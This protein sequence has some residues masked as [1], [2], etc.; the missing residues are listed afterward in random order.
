M[1]SLNEIQYRIWFDD[2]L[3]R[4][5]TYNIG[6]SFSVTGRLSYTL[7]ERSL[8]KIMSE[9]EPFHSTIAMDGKEPRFCVRK[10]F[11]TPFKVIGLDESSTQEDFMERIDEIARFPFDLE[12]DLPCRFYILE[13]GAKSF[14]V[15]CFHH[16]V[17]DA[18]SI[19]VFCDRLSVIYN[20]LKADCEI[21]A[22]GLPSLEEFNDYLISSYPEKARHDDVAYWRNYLKD[23]RLHTSIPLSWASHKKGCD[24]F[25]WQIGNEAYLKACEFCSKYEVTLFRLFTAVW[26]VVLSRFLNNKDLVLDYTAH[27]RT[28]W[29]KNIMGVCFNNLP[30]RVEVDE[31]KSFLDLLS[32]IQKDRNESKP[33][34]RATYANYLKFLR[35]SQAH[36]QEPPFNVGINYPIH[37]HSLSFHF[38]GCSADFFH[39]TAMSL[40]GDLY[41]VIEDDDMLSCRIWYSERVSSVYAGLLA[42][43]FSEVL[44]KVTDAPEQAVR[45]ISML[46]EQR[47]HELIM[48]NSIS[49]RSPG[50]TVCSGRNDFSSVITQFD[51]IALEHCAHTAFVFLDEEYSYKSLYSQ[52]INIAAHIQAWLAGH[53]LSRHK[54]PIA[55]CIESRQYLYACILGIL[56]CGCAYIPIDP[57]FPESRRDFILSDSG[58]MLLLADRPLEIHA[59]G[60]S[61]MDITGFM[62]DA[63]E[64]DF[65]GSVP[66]SPHDT[67]YILYTSGTTGTPKGIPITHGNLM[68]FLNHVRDAFHIDGTSVVLQYANTGFDVSIMEIFM[69]L[70]RGGKLV[71]PANE[72]RK[73]PDAVLR[74]IKR[75]QVNVCSIAPAM[76]TLLPVEPLPCVRL[77]IVGG[78]S[79][80]QETVDKWKNGQTFVN[81]YGPTE[82]TIWVT[83]CIMEDGTPA[84]DIGLPF[85]GVSCYVLDEK[86]NLVPDGIAGELYI[87][88]L[89][90]TQGYL[91][92][93]D[94]NSE[95]FILNPYQSEEDKRHG[96]NGVLYRSG[97]L[98]KRM[99]DNH[100][101]FLG[102][103]D[104]QVKIRGFR[105]ELG[106][107][108][109]KLL[110]Y[111]GVCQAAVAASD[112]RGRKVL[113]AYIQPAAQKVLDMA[114]LKSFLQRE[115]PVYML[116]AVITP[117]QEFPYNSN[118][119][120]DRKRL[121]A[122][123]FREEVR[124]AEAP[125]TGTERRLASLWAALLPVQAIGRSDSLTSLGGDSMAVIQLSFRI[126]EEFGFRIKVADIYRHPVLSDL[127]GFIDRHS[128]TAAQETSG[129]D[130]PEAAAEGPVPLSPTQFSLWLQCVQSAEMKDAYVVPCM[131]ECPPGTDPAV[132]EDALNRLTEVQDAFRISFP[133]DGS[134]KPFI[135]VAGWR[136]FRLEVWDIAGE[137]LGERLNQDI[138]VS[139]DLEQGPLFRCA[140]YRVDGRRYVCSLVMHHLIS[141]G[142]SVRLIRELLLQAVSGQTPDWRRA[143]G[144]YVR[145]ALEAGRFVMTEAYSR[146]LEYW[147]K[148]LDGAVELVFPP[149][150]QEPSGVLDGQLYSRQ[151]PP[152][153]RAGISDFCRTHNSSPFLFYLSAY[154]LLLSR[155]L[156]QSD[157]AVG[158]PFWGREQKKYDRVIGY[159]VNTLPI[160]FKDA[161][162]QSDYFQYLNDVR[163]SLLDAEENAASLREIADA[164]RSCSAGADFALVKTMFSYEEK[165]RLAD[166][167]RRDKSAFDLSMIVSYDSGGHVW[168]ELEYRHSAY[169]HADVERMADAYLALL[170]GIVAH[171]DKPLDS[172][173][174]VPAA[175]RQLVMR[176]NS[177]SQQVEVDI[178]SFLDSFSD[179]VAR[180]P[181]D[182]AVVCKGTVV[183]YKELDEISDKVASSIGHGVRSVG[184]GVSMTAS[185]DC[186]AALVGVLKAGCYYV[187]LDKDLP[188][189]RKAFILRDAA[190]QM[191]FTDES[192]PLAEPVEPDS[193]FALS[194]KES[195]D[196]AYVIYTSGTT[197]LPKGVPITCQ[198]LSLLT[199][200]ERERFGLTE[201]SRVLLFS[202]IS[203]DASVTEIFTTLSVGATLVVA[204]PA[205]RKDPEKLA[206]L[207]EME[208][209]SCATIPPALLPLLPHRDFPALKTLIVGGETT[210]RP[211]IEKWSRGRTLINAYGP[212][213]NTV[214]TTMCVVDGTSESNDIG[215]PL[216][217]VS[218]YVLD[219]RL[220]IVPPG[221]TGELYIGGVRLTGGYLNRP[222]LNREKFV[223]NPYVT[224]EDKAR[225]INTR[226]YRSGDLVRCR[227]DGH[228]IFMGRA[229]TQ[230]KLRGFRIELSE[231]ET[232]LQ[233]LPHVRNALIEVRNGEELAAFVQTDGRPADIAELQRILR[234]KLPPYMVPSK[235]AVVDE[236]PLT[237]NGKIDRRRLPEPDIAVGAAGV[238]PAA[239]ESERLLL[240]EARAVMGTEAVG[241]ETDLPDAGMTSM[242]VMEFVAR[243]AGRMSLRLTASSVYKDRTI[244]RLLRGT[245]ER[246]CYWWNAE[247]KDKPVLVLIAGFPDVSPSYD[248]F[249]QSL[250][251]CFSIFV[252]ESTYAFFAGRDKVLLEDLFRFYEESLSEALQG[253]SVD[254][255]TG[256]C[257]GA[258]LAIAFAEY[259]REH[260]PGTSPY[261]VL[262][263]EAV[264]RR[265]DVG[266]VPYVPEETLKD[267]I[268]AADALYK[269]FPGLESYQGFIVHVMAG[270]CS[271]VIYLEAGEETD[272]N[273][274]RRIRESW[275][276][277][278]RA[279]R[280]HYPSAPYYE[281][282]C[283]HWTFFEESNLKALREIIRKHWHI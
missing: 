216:P 41:L 234:G 114:D 113:A 241:V 266:D 54:I 169:A 20:A 49:Q 55:F 67:A 37:N 225:G 57:S 104:F 23:A 185:A 31:E 174:L 171:P 245:E 116:P 274:I 262:N 21:P 102:R 72:E 110:Q 26:S 65:A 106:E 237:T 111:P 193:K 214:D 242:Q 205:Q 190:C 118:G 244:R 153:L 8:H 282:D 19:E 202:S 231:I 34:Q 109:N 89:Q 201:K 121:P 267:R 143:D 222:D 9:Y 217:G 258:E 30:L 158:I 39:Q 178:P 13:N 186:I 137:E 160:R 170:S 203:F 25:F 32:K 36:P 240:A 53:G 187:P 42:K 146:R 142:W 189:E 108:E 188:D 27:V 5:D 63:D 80:S 82:T 166:C 44:M 68:A 182:T 117:L 156:K 236:F 228:L 250:S 29:G 191:L 18:Q 263:M 176:Q 3:K 280:A 22:S 150:G 247:D 101:L 261:K 209:I 281:L 130:M 7:L 220:N 134:G 138:R 273:V 99:P 6:C 194:A 107:I 14:F 221:M 84:N 58:A 180:C 199:D 227:P 181:W 230:V 115:L 248:S 96:I 204:S 283:D 207:L 212:T 131:F 52:S 11:E 92:R 86:L 206:D 33:H 28:P 132:L 177:V 43:G 112:Y 219:E 239:T 10:E 200:T 123:V 51:K 140:L 218:C 98:V 62:A 157:F 88:G 95:K 211:V 251:R 255:L 70:T 172:Y 152:D 2:M 151:L 145:Y 103:T 159:F 122:P 46:S 229:D 235:W 155:L 73:D 278:R 17:L 119:K 252:F 175:Y 133:M 141:D 126:H 168:C 15:I 1:K 74:L 24:K 97:D 198:A 179:R 144:S 120:I 275:E 210:A 257:M 77:F 259:M 161:Y 270:H 66:V 4:S 215:T 129:E 38:D 48:A 60:V 35:G 135:R 91:N 264:C 83:S 56:R 128:D 75:H 69:T 64:T 192:F 61:A 272:E 164:V 271:N 81:V 147:R 59:A 269:D 249:L 148:Y 260:N 16:I 127:A 125:L 79:T 71:L 162:K 223:D 105:I 208:S 254:I 94:L 183:S 213:E 124:E 163:K 173:P 196:W 233:S 279:W 243:V 256:Y 265:P 232:V 40:P 184:V 93:P 224:S 268:L 90:L 136:P 45:E 100:I 167:L 139:F 238:V 47:K 165:E 149:Q 85:A 87:G 277:N 154:M 78:E 276:A 195:S 197:G 50:F 76:L 246:L 253:R 12:K 226:L